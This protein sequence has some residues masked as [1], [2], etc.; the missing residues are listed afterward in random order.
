MTRRPDGS[1]TLDAALDAAADMLLDGTVSPAASLAV[2]DV[3]RAAGVGVSAFYRAFGSV[4]AFHQEVVTAT[5]DEVFTQSERAFL[6][7]VSGLTSEDLAVSDPYRTIIG[8]YM[9]SIPD[10]LDDPL[11]ACWAWLSHPPSAA[12]FTRTAATLLASRAAI[13]EMLI[14]AFGGSIRPESSGS[15]IAAL[16]MALGKISELC[17]TLSPSEQRPAVRVVEAELL[18]DVVMAALRPEDVPVT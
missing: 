1:T 18:Y 13:Y 10:Q 8:Q 9:A 2:N 7:D 16:H 6:Q 17:S 14:G 3:C 12:A 11:N 5:I 15:Q 4:T